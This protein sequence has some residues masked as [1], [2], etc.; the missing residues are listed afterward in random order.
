MADSKNAKH[1]DSTFDTE[2][3][4][5]QATITRGGHEFHINDA[6]GKE[7]LRWAHTKG[8]Y[9]EINHEGRLVQAVV[10]KSYQY[11][12]DGVS[13]TVD[14]HSDTKT[15]GTVRDNS[16]GAR[17]S[18]TG[19]NIYT[20]GGGISIHGTQDSSIS[21]S[22][23]GDKFE[24]TSGNIVTDH[25]GSVNHNITGDFVECITGN[26]S[27]ILMGDW[28]FNNQSGS[29]DMQI[30][31]GK[32]RLFDASDILIESQTK[33]TFKVG[34]SIIVMKSDGISI[35]SPAIDFVKA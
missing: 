4:Y 19:G 34:S 6:P 13:V 10:D 8:S 35:T 29:V 3:P 31:S 15:S 22:A 2:Y 1:P 25:E 26:K 7:S 14:G 18:E 23:G 9:I 21:S 16:D 33:I 20:G 27:E 28:A 24:T 12:A 5:N 32:F 11:N 30:D 17:S